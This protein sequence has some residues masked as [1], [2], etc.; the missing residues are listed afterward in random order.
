M[1]RFRFDVVALAPVLFALACES[2][3]TP[4]ALE[5]DPTPRGLSMT[6]P[7]DSLVMADSINVGVGHSTRVA[8]QAVN[9]GA[10]GDAVALHEVQWSSQ[11]PDVASVDATGMVSATSLGRAV[12][13][14]TADGIADSVIVNVVTRSIASIR[15]NVSSP[16]TLAVGSQYQARATA[17][18]GGGGILSNRALDWTSSDTS[19]AAVSPTGLVSAKMNGTATVSIASEGESTSF[20]VNVTGGTGALEISLGAS[21]L[22]V[23]QTTQATITGLPIVNGLLTLAG[24]VVAWSSSNE[25]VATVSS[26]GVVTAVSAGTAT[27]HA[28]VNG[29]AGDVN[30]TVSAPVMAA[31]PA[32]PGPAANVTPPQLLTTSVASTPSEGR[33]IHVGAGEDLQAA[34]NAASPGDRIQLEAGATFS[35]NYHLV[36]KA[37]GIDGG[38]ITIQSDGQMPAEGQRMTPSLAA[39]LR[40]PRIISQSVLPAISADPGTSRWR[41][42]GLDL[43]LDPNAPFSN[44]VVELGGTTVKS[45]STIP[46]NIILDRLYVHGTPSLDV[47]RCIQL[48]SDS[49]AV[50]DSY[51]SD[52]HSRGFDSQAIWGWNG[53]GPYKVV[54]NYLE[55][56]TEVIGFGGADPTFPNL[57][58]SDVEIRGNHIT[59]PMSWKGGPWLVKNLFEFKTGRRILVQGNVIENSWVQAQLGWAFM[60]W[61]VNQDGG[62]GWC[63]TSD[64]LIQ[65]NLIRNVSAGFN[66]AEK[67][68][69]PSASTTRIAIRNNVM[70]G[71]DNP[72]VSGGGFGFLI[73]GNI[74]GLTIEHNTGFVPTTSSIQWSNNG[75]LSNHIIRNNLMG[76]GTYP[77]FAVPSM[78][79]ASFTTG[80]S[81]F[82]GNVIAL[83]DYF[84]RGFPSGNLYPGSMDAI[85]LAGGAASAYSVSSSPA[86]LALSSSSPYKGKATDGTDPGA[87]VD[88]IMAAIANVIV[89]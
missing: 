1:R 41:L 55:A 22:L 11:D 70:I 62:C 5:H 59:R 43:T 81:D 21:S 61:S 89:P 60:I 40:A 26:G 64:L 32:D 74:P 17:F 86:S 31:P 3:V 6:A 71:V 80:G 25:G 58:P 29:Y 82:S 49:T 65:D 15:V 10:T 51:V 72:T 56:S 9:A 47:R 75:V 14:V 77:I 66:L 34:L 20:T 68:A 67:Y 42:I 46:R 35:G 36:P 57:I 23:G 12:I 88:R 76:G 2:S 18:D 78:L 4:K 69:T 79:W 16:L 63:G 48:N 52:C 24:R 33:T 13:N 37:G 54:N 83:A 87:N 19:V 45:L 30:V 53:N 50:V 73:Q 28:S 38:W 84:A 39:S 27:I 44:V 85:G 8:V 7:L